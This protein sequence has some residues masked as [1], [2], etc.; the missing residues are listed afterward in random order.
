EF[1]P[2][3]IQYCLAVNQ[4]ELL[5]RD[6]YYKFCEHSIGKVTF[7]E[8]LEPYIMTDKLTYLSAIVMKD[9]I[10]HYQTIGKVK[11]VE[12]CLLHLDVINLDI[13]QM[14]KL[15][16]SH[17]LYDAILYVY[18]RGM[19]DYTTPLEV[20]ERTYPYL[21]ILLEFDTQEFL[22][23]LSMA[24]EE[25]EFDNDFRGPDNT[26][27]RQYI[28][29]ILL[30]LM[31]QNTGFSPTQVGSLFTF[32]ARQMAKHENTIHVNK[33]LFEQ[34]LEY[35]ANPDDDSRHE[36]RQQALL[37]LLVAGV[38]RQF[39]DERILVLAENAKFVMTDDIYTDIE[40]EE[41]KQAAL[42]SLQ[43]LVSISCLHMANLVLVHFPDT[44][45]P[46]V[47]RLEDQPK[48][49]YEFLK[50]V[51]D[52]RSPV[53]KQEVTP[54]VDVHERYIYLMCQFE[55]DQAVFNYLRASDNYRIEETLAA[56]W[57][58]LLESVMAPQRKCQDTSC[59]YFR[60]FG[61]ACY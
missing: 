30:Q 52:S 5:F 35:L 14:V 32:L 47:Y 51:F 61:I 26:S 27:G 60:A 37:E 56:L 54:D 17:C 49:Q 12:S 8:S 20:T 1:I 53:A 18:N 22:N 3:F 11:E 23:V 6:I 21:R 13:H 16:W 10:E 25:K 45:T 38:L 55:H 36:E 46:V 19:R 59:D 9:F 42:N 34:V 58:P 44:L 4:T 40:R 48:T 33:V 41:V 7:L 50:G 31:V 43:E 15:C 28:V 2:V 24:F 39:D 29:N 57:F